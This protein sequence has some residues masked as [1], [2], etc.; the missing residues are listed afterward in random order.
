MQ[1]YEKY[2]TNVTI[3]CIGSI[4]Y[5]FQELLG[6]KRRKRTKIFNQD[7]I[8]KVYREVNR[9][10]S[11]R[12]L[13]KHYDIIHPTYY[14]PYILD[15]YD[16]KLV[17]TIHDMIHEI[18]PDM[19]QQWNRDAKKKM[20]LAAD[21]IVTISECTK[22]DILKYYPDINENKISIIPL[23]S[24]L[25]ELN[26]IDRV[27]NHRYILF[28]GTRNSYKNFV[29]FF[30]AV[31]SILV[32]DK[33]LYLVS[34]GGGKYDGAERELIGSLIDRCIQINADDRTLISL[35]TYAE[36]FV[37]PSLYE[38]FGI[39][40]LEAFSCKCP[41]VASDASS[42]PEVAGDAAI[43]FNPYDISDMSAKIEL[44]VYD[45]KCKAAMVNRGIDR[46]RA[47]DWNKSTD[48]L[49]GCYQSLLD[50]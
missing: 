44:A 47:Y 22:K 2:N 23:A 35:Y 45:E 6:T 10:H 50:K 1:N 48:M 18:F 14:D 38:G 41:V 21:H 31:S 13:K 15:H 27:I 17:I 20:A 40:L 43:Y 34:V 46:L 32:K 39:P 26:E 9:I 5:Y 30:K 16:G 29:N 49:V 24:S 42:L 33:N 3:E 36:C 4:N 11:K 12:M 25:K 37:F 28:V 7:I 8:D 19:F